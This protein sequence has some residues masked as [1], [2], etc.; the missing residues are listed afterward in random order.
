LRC[1]SPSHQRP[2]TGS[3][4]ERGDTRD[5]NAETLLVLRQPDV[6]NATA[7]NAGAAGS[8]STAPTVSVLTLFAC[9]RRPAALAP[10]GTKRAAAKAPIR[11]PIASPIS[12]ENLKCT[13]SYTR[14]LLTSATKA[15]SVGHVRAAPSAEALFVVHV[16]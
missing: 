2:A 7:R 13:P 6:A 4:A 9:P 1:L 14:A 16:G 5:H 12:V 15:S 3:V 10:Q 8:R 11:C